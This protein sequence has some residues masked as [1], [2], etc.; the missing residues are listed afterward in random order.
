MKRMSA[1]RSLPSWAKLG[2]TKADGA[3]LPTRNIPARM[4]LPDGVNGPA[5]LVYANYTSI[6]RY[7]C[8]HLYAITVGE[9][10]DQLAAR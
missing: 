3:P 9:L 5:Y 2:V 4:V 10:S 6:L 8:A 7:N 1:K